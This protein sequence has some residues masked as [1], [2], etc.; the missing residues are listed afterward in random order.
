MGL[1]AMLHSR[2]AATLDTLVAS[3][4]LPEAVRGVPFKVEPPGRGG[5]GHLAT[6][7]ALALG[8]RAGRPPRDVAGL[9]AAALSVAPEV[10]K[11][12]VAGPGFLNVE[13]RPEAFHEVLAEVLREGPTYGRARAAGGQRVLV[14]FV[15]A[16]PTG[17]LLLSH[18]RGAV[19][20]D[21]VAR[22]LEIAGYRVTREYYVNDYGNQVRLLGESVLCRHEGREPPE[23][24]YGGFYVDALVAHFRARAAHLLER[25]PEGGA[26]DALVREA[27]ALMMVGVP[28]ADFAG[29]RPTL[30][31]LGVEHDVF[32]SEDGLHR[33]G[34]VERALAQLDAQGRLQRLDDGAVVFVTGDEDDKNRVVRKR[35]GLTTYFAS[36]IAYHAD[37]LA[38]GFEH[39]IDVWGADH[40][41]YIARMRSGLEAMGGAPERLEVL[42]VQMVSLMRDGQPFRMGKRLGNLI[43]IEEVLDEID[44]AVGRPGAGR[45]AV[46]Y[47]YLARRT[48]AQISLDVEVAKKQS[49]NNPVFYL[50]YGY[51]RLCAI[52]RRAREVFGLEIPAWSPQLAA[53]VVHPLELDLLAELGRYPAVLAEAAAE[54][55]PLKVLTFA[56]RLAQAFQS[57]YTQLSVEGD[58]ILPRER[59]R[60]PGWEARWDREQTRG[61]LLWVEAIRLTYE[62]ALGVLGI[63]APERMTRDEDE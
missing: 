51:A 39:L 18:A 10:E 14:E 34:F 8:K 6:N 16:N 57:Y 28:G 38:R 63:A 56:E 31:R 23:G 13:L 50:Q 40:H 53:R 17:P 35:D 5:S 11:V 43:T 9:L 47:F 32:T 26:S 2:V 33:W 55:E 44:E 25:A 22:L 42:L 3:G 19:T 62:S 45:D 21:V 59:D 60:G 41:G 29:I 20:G 52:L 37:K 46:R 54:R 49:A 48:D 15:S 1:E 58:S 27:I 7:V 61:R 36:D 4:A 12:A 30:L 24:G